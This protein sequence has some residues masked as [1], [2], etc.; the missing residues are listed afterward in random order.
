MKKFLL[1]LQFVLLLILSG[2]AVLP[3]Q[4]QAS[5][6]AAALPDN[7]LP[8]DLSGETRR[9]SVTGSAQV[10]VIPDEVLLTLGVETHDKDLDIARTANDRI[11]DRVL[12]ITTA[13][14][15][16]E[17]YVQT[18]YINIEPRYQD[19]Y[20]QTEFIGYFVR[21]NIVITLRDLTKFEELYSRLLDAGVNYVHGVEFRTT[22]LRKYRDQARS[23]AIQAAQEKASALAGELD[24]GV[25][26]PLLIQENSNYWWSGYSSWWGS[27]G[28]GMYQNVVQNTSEMPAEFDSSLAPGQIAVTA[29]VTVEFALK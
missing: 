23:L 10:M 17:K 18:D 26:A 2:C 15:I 29:S 3:A 25:G 12:E 1:Y 7:S 6:N 11:I 5:L 4:S 19:S 13:M 14:G 27:S 28:S 22:G 9:I 20:T 16:D 8:A 24:E 21:K